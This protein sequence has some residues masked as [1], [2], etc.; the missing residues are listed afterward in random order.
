MQVDRAQGC[1]TKVHHEDPI[2][3]GRAHRHPLPGQGLA[4]C[5]VTVLGTVDGGV[6]VASGVETAAAG[7]VPAETAETV[8]VTVAGVNLRTGPSTAAPVAGTLTPANILRVTGAAEAGDG[9]SWLPV[10]DEATG[11]AGYVAEELVA[12]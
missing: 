1:P 4:G 3:R 6:D 2:G 10:V 5:G 11:T 12:N 9:R 8:R 7:D